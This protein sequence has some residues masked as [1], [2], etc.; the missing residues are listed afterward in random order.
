MP[1]PCRVR[2]VTVFGSWR[3]GCYSLIGYSITARSAQ[4]T[5]SE[6]HGPALSL[7]E[8]ARAANKR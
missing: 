7:S 8:P 2:E 6:M 4:A 3:R 1:E 5:I